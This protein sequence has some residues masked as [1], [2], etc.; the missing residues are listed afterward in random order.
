MSRVPAG[1]GRWLLVVACVVVVSTLAA[2]IVVMGPPAAQRAEK[3]DRKRAHDLW[4]I[5][6]AVDSYAESK[7]TLPPDLDTLAGQPGQRLPTTDP[8]GGSPYGYEI[9]GK[10]SYRLCAVFTTDT[11]AT[12]EVGMPWSS[13]E[14]KHGTGRQCFDR[15]VKDERDAGMR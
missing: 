10:R 4:R 14:W 9:T 7:G 2:A 6:R 11:A 13:E 5:E 12:Q 15:K 3:L 1:F 8:D